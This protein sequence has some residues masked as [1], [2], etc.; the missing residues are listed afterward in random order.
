MMMSAANY[1]MHDHAP[2]TLGARRAPLH[3][4]LNV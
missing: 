1:P 4:D 3:P 2:L